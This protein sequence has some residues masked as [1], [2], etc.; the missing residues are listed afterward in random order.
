MDKVLITQAGEHLQAARRIMLIS[1]ARPDG[2]AIGSLLGLGLGLQQD[3]TE[4]QMLSPDGVP[5]NFRY[6]AGTSEIVKKASGEFDL[7]I[8]LDTATPERLGDPPPFS[9][10]HNAYMV[11]LNIDHHPSNTNYGQINLIQADAVATAVMLVELFPQWGMSF[12]PE[13]VDALL[14]GILTDSL[15]FRTRNMNAAALRAAATL[16]DAGGD[17]PDL[18]AKA[19]LQRSLAATRFW[20]AGLSRLEIQD[21]LVWT[22]L[23]LAARKEAGYSGYDDADL[24]NVL[25]NIKDTNTAVIFVEQNPHKVKVSWRSQDGAD[26]SRVAAHFGG[27]GHKSAAGAMIE[28]T[29]QE[30]QKKVIQKTQQMLSKEPALQN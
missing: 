5:P 29:L 28:G 13:I 25:S 27:G 17:L 19:L 8:S 12:T 20:G 18:Y 15:G 3:G 21:G 26:V 10:P 16:V 14:T 2:D 30:V 6:L 4:V 23:T 24:V 11:D 7:Y 1:H 22:A 9:P